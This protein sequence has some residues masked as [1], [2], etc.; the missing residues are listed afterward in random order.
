MAGRLEDKVCIVTG[1]AR[2][3]GRRF[4]IAL[5]EHGARVAT[6]D[7][8]VAEP[9]SGI[10]S[11]H[12]DVTSPKACRAAVAE[13]VEHLGPVDVL[14][15]NAALYATLPMQRY[16]EID[17]DLWD[18]VMAVNLRG[19]FNMIQAVGPEMETRG[20][21]RIIQITSGTVYKGLPNMLHYIT[22]KGGLAAMTRALSRELGPKGITVN[23]I[24]P[25][26]TLSDSILANE[27]HIEATRAKVIAT[28]AIPRDGHPEDLLGALVFLASDESAFMTGQTLVVDGGSVNT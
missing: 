8:A 5:A 15:N 18:D 28:R 26:L 19:A 25:G 21:G 27:D 10:L 4:V 2:G 23:A 3:L 1:G 20:R 17:P 11:L 7:I 13:V 6:L 24:A 16:D 9:P 14:V 22:S 12:C